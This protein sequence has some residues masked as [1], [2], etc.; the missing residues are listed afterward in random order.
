M[1][2]VVTIAAFLVAI[3]V[4]VVFHEFGHYLVARLCNVKVLRFSIGFGKPLWIRKFGKDSTELAVCLLPL[5]G[6]VRMLDEREGEVFPE[7]LHRAFNRQHVIRRILIVIAG[8]VANLFL[9]SFIYTVLFIHGI[10]GI[11]PVLGFVPPHSIAAEAH[12]APGDVV[13]TIGGHRISTWQSMSVHLSEAAANGKTVIV[14]VARHGV[15]QNFR[16]NFSGIGSSSINSGLIE[17]LG[18][19]PPEPFVSGVLGE[20]EPGS[21]A[22][23]SGL[24]PGD[25][26]MM[27]EG[28]AYTGWEDLVQAVR[29]HPGK[30]LKLVVNHGNKIEYLTIKPKSVKTGGRNIGWIGAG[31]L[32]DPAQIKA[33][34]TTEHYGFIDASIHG[35]TRTLSMSWFTLE[36]IAKLVMGNAALS[37]L[38]GPLT[39]ADYAGQSARMGMIPYLTFLALVSISLGILNLLPIPLLD[40]GHLLY[41]MAEIVK[42][43]P[44]SDKAQAIGQRIG[45]VLL[46]VLMVFAFYNDINRIFIG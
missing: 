40:G 1:G 32:I 38:S 30:P 35:V 29:S 12:L 20:I 5:G 28:Q 33:L 25:K 2:I 43:G 4:L 21:P 10:P 27:I 42:G 23:Q 14:T 9:A 39:I 44:V 41:Y 6:F 19:L 36:M 46:V 24:V 37:N 8:P 18:F 3:G 31:P 17:R 11:R 15:K 22:D 26:I 13:D 45:G 7:E 16:L 34:R